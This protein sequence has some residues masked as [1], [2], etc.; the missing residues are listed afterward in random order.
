MVNVLL[1]AKADID[2]PDVNGCTPAHLAAQEGHL[3]VLRVKSY[4]PP[5][6]YTPHISYIVG[7][8]EC[9]R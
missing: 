7:A 2:A 8:G 9:G 4:P 6:L 5:P 3:K 1:A